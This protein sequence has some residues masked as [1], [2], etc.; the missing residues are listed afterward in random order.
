MPNGYLAIKGI[1]D[2]SYDIF[3]FIAAPENVRVF[4]LT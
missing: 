1:P 2:W 3:E 4:Y